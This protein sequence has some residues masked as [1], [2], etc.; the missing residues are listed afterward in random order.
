MQHA[1]EQL[2]KLVEN[3]ES[4]FNKICTANAQTSRK[5]ACFTEY[6]AETKYETNF[7]T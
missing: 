6:S 2:E 1:F 7:M 5:N 4:L 3:F